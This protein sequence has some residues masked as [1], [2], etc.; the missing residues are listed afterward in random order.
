MKYNLEKKLYILINKKSEIHGSNIRLYVR[1][2]TGETMLPH[3]IKPTV[4]HGG[5]NIQIW[6]CFAISACT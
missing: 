6:G 1:R 2:Q 5:G 4:K 3:C